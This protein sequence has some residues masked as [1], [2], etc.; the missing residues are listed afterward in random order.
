M[1]W[2]ED[3]S[4]RESQYPL[5]DVRRQVEVQM[6]IFCCTISVL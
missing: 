2:A 4:I 5:Y 6:V 1:Q 3:P